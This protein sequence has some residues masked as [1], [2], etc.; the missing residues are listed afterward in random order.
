MTDAMFI[1]VPP[2]QLRHEA[3]LHRHVREDWH[4]EFV[5]QNNR[6]LSLPRNESQS[7]E[8]NAW[9][10]RSQYQPLTNFN[11]PASQLSPV[12]QQKQRQDNTE[13][14]FD[15][16][17]F[18]RAFDAAKIEDFHPELYETTTDTS[19]VES[20]GMEEDLKTWWASDPLLRPRDGTIDSASSEQLLQSIIAHQQAFSEQSDSENF[21]DPQQSYQPRIGS[22]AILEEAS[23]GQ[24]EQHLDHEADELARTAGQ[25]LDNLKYDQSQ[26]FENSTFLA[27]MR[28]LR[29]REVRVEGDRVVDVSK[30]SSV[31]I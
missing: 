7:Y 23:K 19:Q 25:L 17:A 12:A 10:P 13:D 30:V 5:L 27:L 16:A 29:D 4:Q 20:Q 24:E 28:Q 18:E 26:K 1:P 6:Q 21:T 14:I 9:H 31:S 3:P 2:S 11:A 8:P 15:E 22:D